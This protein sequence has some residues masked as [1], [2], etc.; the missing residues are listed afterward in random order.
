MKV[1]VCVRG[2]FWAFD[3]ARE[4]EN[5]GALE[6]LI[7]S[8]P[9]SLARRFGV[10]PDR[11]RAL[12][13]YELAAR[14]ARRLPAALDRALE[15]PIAAAFARAA[16]KHLPE[17]PQVF[18][19]WSGSSLEPM[20]RAKARGAFTVLE[21]GSAHIETQREIL[22]EV[23]RSSGL[24]LR[25]PPEGV[26]RRE[27]LEYALADR[28]AVPSEFVART[29]RERG[30]APERLIV[31]PFG[32]D[33]AAFTPPPEPAPRPRLLCVGRVGARKGSH[34]LLRAFQRGAYPGELV[35]VGPIEREFASVARQAASDRVHFLG[36]V[37]QSKLPELYQSASAFALASFEEGLAMVLLQAMASGLPLVVSNHTGAE[38]LFDERDGVLLFPA[39]NE[40]ALSAQLRRL[41]ADPQL[42]RELGQRATAR[43]ARGFSWGDYGARALAAYRRGLGLGPEVAEGWP[44]TTSAAD[45]HQNT[46]APLPAP[47]PAPRTAAPR[48]TR[49]SYPWVPPHR[50]RPAA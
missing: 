11:V 23:A 10:P 41:G 26:V 22:A 18:V 48:S 2:R 12:P 5:A 25:L 40:E 37:P 1:T 42:G 34:L 27:L 3:L 20:R 43:V 6:R 29:F 44:H 47:S 14:G 24:S 36:P 30:F 15:A 16:A 17:A 7:T 39:G 33:L 13:G 46:V 35:F 45:D 19:G 8:S 4:L 49:P 38:G 9:V 28:I 32:V 31:N 21:R 50:R